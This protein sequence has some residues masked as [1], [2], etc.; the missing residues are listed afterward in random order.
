[1]EL[2]PL[3]REVLSRLLDGDDE[4]RAVLRSQVPSLRVTSRE[5]TG[6]GFF[7]HL[8]IG[9]DSPRLDPPHE[10]H[11]ISGVQAEISGLDDRAGFVLF[12]TDGAIDV[13]EGFTYVEPWPDRVDQFRVL[14]EGDISQP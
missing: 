11:A 4:M 5:S 10:R 9:D 3:E 1:M 13:L 7:T 6:V 12:V 14:R 2:L 8:T